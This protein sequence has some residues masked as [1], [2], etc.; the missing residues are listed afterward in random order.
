MKAVIYETYGSPDVLQM[1]EVETPIP[2]DH[3][4]LVKV[5]ATG[6]NPYDWRHIEAKPALIRIAGAGF[7]KP[8]HQIMGADIAGVV[9]AVGKDVTDFKPG[10]AVMGECGYGG[11]AEYVAVSHKALVHKP[12]NITFAEAASIPMVALTAL[13][14]LRDTGQIQAGQS[15]LINGASGGIG[16]IA[17]QLA[18]YYGAEVT[19]VCSTR[20]L[21][22]VRS[23]GADHVIDYTK[24]DFS[25][26][27]ETYDL[28]F[29]TV[30][31][32]TAG[33]YSRAL[34]PHGICSVAGFKSLPHM[35]VQLGLIASLIK[36]RS[37]KSIGSMG[38]ARIIKDDLLFIKDRLEA[39]DIK[40]VI[41]RCYPFEETADAIR[42]LR[43]GRARGKVV[44]NVV[45]EAS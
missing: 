24:Q 44:I 27:G 36:R 13:Q 28:I 39:G 32:R 38:T 43:T 16:T 15:V 22:L 42:Y 4:V 40:P 1:R 35:I 9:E 10:D 14:G 20:N 3:E 31:N 2:A 18:K 12:E 7:W 33:A 30:S 21:D 5:M 11:F 26:T 41:D 19:S 17:V 37:G 45:P 34:K 23:L 6:T 25:R 29:C 8:V